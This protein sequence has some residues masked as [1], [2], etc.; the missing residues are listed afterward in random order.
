VFAIG[1]STS[2]NSWLGVIHN[3]WGAESE[4]APGARM[5]AIWNCVNRLA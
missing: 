5:R 4:D 2:A 1:A 3:P